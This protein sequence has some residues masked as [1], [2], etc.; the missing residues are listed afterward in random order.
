[1][2]L[3][4]LIMLGDDQT[5]SYMNHATGS[6]RGLSQELEQLADMSVDDVTDTARR[7]FGGQAEGGSDGR[8]NSGASVVPF[9]GYAY[10][11]TQ[12]MKVA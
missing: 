7:V 4:L 5:V 2:L 3:Q 12:P 8:G 6:W 9:R 11:L 1:M 10:P